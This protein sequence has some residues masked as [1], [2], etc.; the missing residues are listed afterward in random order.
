MTTGQ[1]IRQL[2]K[3][4]GLTAA[5][6]SAALSKRYGVELLVSSISMYENDQRLPPTET[7]DVLADFFK[8]SLD[9]LRGRSDVRNPDE[10]LAALSYPAEV[11]EFARNL[12]A[13]PNGVRRDF[14]ER[15][16]KIFGEMAEMH[17]TLSLSLHELAE[18]RDALKE[19]QSRSK[20]KILS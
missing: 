1:R 7:C 18:E 3:E 6:M 5:E 8:V 12:T 10:Q 9:Y 4:Q 15:F 19:W 2:R 20:V 13:L 14:I 16:A 11:Q 17:R